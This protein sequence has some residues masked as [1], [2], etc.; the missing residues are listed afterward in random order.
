VD[1][2]IEY[3]RLRI[4]PATGRRDRKRGRAARDKPV[5]TAIAERLA[6]LLQIQFRDFNL[7]PIASNG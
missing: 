1:L 4:P 7:S 5:V 3:E 2:T 6:V